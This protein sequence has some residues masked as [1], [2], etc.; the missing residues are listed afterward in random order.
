MIDLAI[1]P[2]R[3]GSQG[4]LGKN[5]ANLGGFPLITW[6]IRAACS[7][8]IFKRVIV[9]TDTDEIAKTAEAAGAEV[10]FI[11]PAHLA[12]SGAR[13][14]DVL[15]HALDVT[16]TKG[17]FALLQPTSPFRSAKHLTEAVAQFTAG[18]ADSL[19]SVAKGKPLQWKF[20]RT[21]DGF[22]TR[23]V[24]DQE[25]VH[26]RQDGEPLYTPNGAIYLCTTRAFRAAES[27]FFADMLGYEMSQIDSIDIDA[28]DDLAL[29]RAVVEQGLRAIDA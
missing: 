11:R 22:L 14:A 6:T 24:K 26:R 12:T 21:K 17:T 10:P 18:K 28:P 20:S 4:L 7:S 16:G 25:I 29:A 2:A 8:S 19:I 13:S 27:L 15:L 5:I 9:S 23:I 3:A 1:I